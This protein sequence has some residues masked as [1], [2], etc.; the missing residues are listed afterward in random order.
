MEYSSFVHDQTVLL[1]WFNDPVVDTVTNITSWGFAP[2]AT[3]HWIILG[4][5]SIMCTVMVLVSAS[6]SIASVHWFK[7]LRHKHDN[8][9][10]KMCECV[11][12]LK[13]KA[14]TP[15]GP[16]EQCDANI[17]SQI[18]HKVLFEDHCVTWGPAI[19][20]YGF[21][22]FLNVASQCLLT[23]YLFF[24]SV[25][26]RFYALEFSQQVEFCNISSILKLVALQMFLFT[27]FSQLSYFYR[28]ACIIFATKYRVP[29]THNTTRKIQNYR[30]CDRAVLFVVCWLSEVLQW[31]FL[32]VCGSGYLLFANSI[33]DL[34]INSLSL[35]FILDVDE[36]LFKVLTPVNFG[37]TQ[38]EIFVPYYP[39][40][41][42]E[43]TVYS[44]CQFVGV[45][46]TTFF[47]K[48]FSPVLAIYLVL[49]LED[50]V[51][52][53][54]CPG[55]PYCAESAITHT[56]TNSNSTT[57]YKRVLTSFDMVWPFIIVSFFAVN[58]IGRL[59]TIIETVVR[60]SCS[61]KKKRTHQKVVATQLQSPVAVE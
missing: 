25:L 17:Y 38:Y 44:P 9:C 1:E 47:S 18:V 31:L 27:R 8:E 4:G 56:F 57:S 60:Q 34:I 3:Q 12:F 43:N 2:E 22:W 26:P 54:Y 40:K 5:I 33:E 46:V 53:S 39:P 21:G 6:C 10:Q 41:K 59:I 16:W 23:F 20:E 32:L 51:G 14:R 19:T 37:A 50:Y 28:Q 61:D 36:M 11:G 52:C 29:D 30:A 48:F 42:T 24:G 15:L 49:T 13:C 55:G 35:E 45:C 58:E 7:T